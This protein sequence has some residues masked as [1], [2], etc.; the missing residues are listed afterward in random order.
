MGRI[1]LICIRG[2]KPSPKTRNCCFYTEGIKNTENN[3]GEPVREPGHQVLV[4]E[5]LLL[6]LQDLLQLWQAFLLHLNGTSI[7]QN[8]SL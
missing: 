6:S 4:G 5:Q 8:T 2:A 3:N 1:Q 7:D